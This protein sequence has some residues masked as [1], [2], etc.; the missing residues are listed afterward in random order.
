MRGL[1]ISKFRCCVSFR[2]S[3][4][5]PHQ[6]G[7]SHFTSTDVD[8]AGISHTY[9]FR[10]EL[11]LPPIQKTT[12]SSPS[13]PR[14]AGAIVGALTGRPRQSRIFRIASGGWSAAM[15]R[16]RPPQRSHSRTSN[17]KFVGRIDVR[18]LAERAIAGRERF[19]R[20]R[21]VLEQRR[22]YEACVSAGCVQAVT[23][24]C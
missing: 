23:A 12:C 11:C 7:A 15:I 3:L 19:S 10:L 18:Q 6:I 5:T 2:R 8:E 13:R 20:S 22:I 14:R 17:A 1:P 4:R 16:M 9:S 21:F 24:T